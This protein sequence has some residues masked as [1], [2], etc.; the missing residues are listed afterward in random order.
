MSSALLVTSSKLTTPPAF[1][2]RRRPPSAA[3]VSMPVI[4]IELAGMPTQSEIPAVSSS[5]MSS[6]A[7]AS[8]PINVTLDAMVYVTSAISMFDALTPSAS[9]AA[10][11]TLFSSSAERPSATSSPDRVRSTETATLVNSS[12]V[13]SSAGGAPDE[14]PNRMSISFSLTSTTTMSWLLPRLI[15]PR[16]PVVTVRLPVQSPTISVP[17]VLSATITSTVPETN[18]IL[19]AFLLRWSTA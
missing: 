12:S 7:S 11:A 6:R 9:P 1:S 5:R 16:F 2:T 15:V 17:P 4:F 13:G 14:I 10:E 18:S 8:S 19:P 3:T